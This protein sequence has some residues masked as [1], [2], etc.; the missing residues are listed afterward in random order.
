MNMLK[1]I[2]FLDMTYLWFVRGE[3]ESTNERVGQSTER[4]TANN[5]S[6]NENFLLYL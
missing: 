3:H 5:P 4:E 1:N 2:V 6:V